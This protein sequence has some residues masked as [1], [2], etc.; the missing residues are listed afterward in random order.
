MSLKKV[1]FIDRDGTLIHEPKDHQVDTYEKFQ[2]L[3]DVVPSLLDLQK[4]GYRLVMV[5][6][7]DGLGTRS[8]PIAHFKRVHDL[9]MHVFESQGVHF[10][11]VLICPHFLKDGCDCRKPGLGM[12]RHWLQGEIDLQ[13]SYVIGDRKTD[14]QLAVNMGIQPIRIGFKP[15][16]NWPAITQKLL[17]SPRMAEVERVT[18][19]TRIRVSVDLDRSGPYKLNTGIGFFDHMLE[20]IAKHGGFALSVKTKG[21]LH[22]DEHHTVED[23]AIALGEAIR[24]ALGDKR[25]IGRY[26]FVLPMDEAQ[27][28]VSIDLSGRA[29]LVFKGKF[30]RE[31]VGGLPTELVAHFFKS[32]ADGLGATLHIRV[33][34]EN[35]HHKVEAA[36]KCVAR[37]LRMAIS[38]TQGGDLPSTKGVL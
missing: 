6:N 16:P 22:V 32:F 23:T 10:D 30:D 4:A 13:H 2:L 29:Y 3:P 38:R 8:F 31:T 7:Q 33:E 12:V 9:T 26:G 27:A 19:E 35:D 36:F 25:G 20:Q 24:K 5:T 28:Q 15:Y 14:V 18:R 34:G 37:A 17:N 21:D 11:E 1:L